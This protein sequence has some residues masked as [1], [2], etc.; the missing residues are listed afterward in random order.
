AAAPA[1]PPEDVKAVSLRRLFAAMLPPVALM[2]GVLGSIL[3]G[4]ATPT[5]AAGVGAVGAI[6][7]AGLRADGGRPLPIRVGILSII[8]LLLLTALFDLRIARNEIPDAD[9]IAIGVAFILC[10]GIAW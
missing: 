3:A 7:L 2:V 4:I 6:L 10:A 5:E 1:L 8:A 9:R